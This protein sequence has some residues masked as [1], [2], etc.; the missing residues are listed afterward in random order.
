MRTLVVATCPSCGRPHAEDALV[1]ALCGQLLKH[2][3]R[4]S[5]PSALG[6][7]GAPSS[8]QTHLSPT[9]VSVD[10]CEGREGREARGAASEPWVFL[11]IGLVTA[12]VF[13]LTPMLGYM[14]WFLA[15]LVHEMGHAAVAWLCGMPAV[16]AI[17]LEGHA[18]AVH[19][20]QQP[21]L[22]AFV[23][24]GLAAAAWKLFE[25]RARWIVLAL[26]AVLYP[27]L[28]LT[29]AKELVHLLAGHGAE[30]AFATLC[31][32]KTLDGGFTAS[33]L[34][35]ALYG[36]VGWFLLGKNV[37][38]CWGLMT[39]E[40]A[41]AVYDANGSFGLTNDYI[42]VAEEVL[43]WPLPRVAFGMLVACL[44]VV[45]AAI[46]LWRVRSRPEE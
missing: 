20:E 46:V 43:G 12:P 5:A 8:S 32:W 33:R 23:G 39:S 11:G 38:L 13:A 22:V 27:L 10:D 40:I 31:L 35:R 2:A 34:E 36:T 28:A 3:Q 16:P 26:V 14:G 15:S 4:S 1:C 30:L 45:P 17:S 37:F 29:G 7:P 44:M 24:C 41:R 6:V 21:A 18:A 9:T 42:R 25:G 19:S